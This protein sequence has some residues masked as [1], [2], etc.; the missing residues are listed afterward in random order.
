MPHD[1]IWTGRPLFP[2]PVP[3]TQKARGAG[4]CPLCSF[5]PRQSFPSQGGH[6]DLC[7]RDKCFLEQPE[8]KASVRANNTHP[9]KTTSLQQRPV[10][11]KRFPPYIDLPWAHGLVPNS[12]TQWPLSLSLC[13]SGSYRINEVLTLCTY[14]LH[15]K[16]EKHIHVHRNKKLF[17]AL[18]I[19]SL[20]SYCRK[21]MGGGETDQKKLETFSTSGFRI[22]K[23]QE[24]NICFGAGGG[25]GPAFPPEQGEGWLTRRDFQPSYLTLPHEH[26]RLSSEPKSNRDFSTVGS[27]IPFL[28]PLRLNT[29]IRQE[30]RLGRGKESW[31]FS[32][33]FGDLHRAYLCTSSS[34]PNTYWFGFSSHN[35]SL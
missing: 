16:Y 27:K 2:A 22:V 28:C 35:S 11:P 6:S 24:W 25:P 9:R 4:V 19:P 21:R 3:V 31:W 23:H 20:R 32:P 10:S 26:L 18:L 15:P 13:V 14:M 1:T 12:G 17:R 8:T 33:C 30:F 34:W 29:S 7:W 5:F